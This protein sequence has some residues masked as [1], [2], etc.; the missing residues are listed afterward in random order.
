MLKRE[1]IAGMN[2]M[3]RFYSFDYFLSC[4]EATGIRSL[5]LW[6]GSP[7]F[8]IDTMGY[9][10]CLEKKKQICGHRLKVVSACVPSMAYQYQYGHRNKEYRD[11]SFLFF[12]NGIKAA[13]A[14]GARIAVVNSGCCEVDTPFEE[15]VKG[16]AELL[17]RLG[18]VAG[19]EGVT[20]AIESL[21]ADETNIADSLV[22]TRE[23]IRQADTPNLK[24]MADTVAVYAAGE[25][26]E[27][28]FQAFGKDLIHMHFIDG[29][30]KKRTYDH[31]IWGDGDFP[32]A[33]MVQCME[34]YGYAGYLTQELEYE[35]YYGDP[36]EAER[37]NWKALSET[38]LCKESG[39]IRSRTG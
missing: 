21:T 6:L 5:E 35:A 14:M 7:H 9:F 16:P 11:K 22:H 23:L 34:K 39:D 28:W 33:E 30:M 27:E 4:M 26:L 24:A 8:W 36:A 17:H 37:K 18:R 19:Q 10:Q 13:V 32:L 38:V 31:L 25:T 20:M 12:S 15:A 2:Q 1:Q 3:Y 29:F